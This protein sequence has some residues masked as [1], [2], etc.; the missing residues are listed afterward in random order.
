MSR[1]SYFLLN[2]LTFGGE[3][4]GAALYPQEYYCYSFLLEA[5]TTP[6]P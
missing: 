1:L 4:E 3:V 6:G 5:E 2:W